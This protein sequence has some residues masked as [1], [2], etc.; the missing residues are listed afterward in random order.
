MLFKLVLVIFLL[1][2]FAFLIG[3][4]CCCKNFDPFFIE[5]SSLNKQHLQFK[6]PAFLL[7]LRNVET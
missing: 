6:T 7:S 4:F 1:F 2:R 3:I 5:I